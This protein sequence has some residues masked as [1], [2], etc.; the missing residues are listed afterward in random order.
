[1]RLHY[2]SSFGIT[3]SKAALAAATATSLALTTTSLA[4]ILAF[5]FAMAAS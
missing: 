4:A 3:S 5:R 1:M 2:S